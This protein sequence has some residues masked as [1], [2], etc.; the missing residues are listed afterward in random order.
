MTSN[1]F[2]HGV[3]IDNIS[4]I[5]NDDHLTAFGIA[6]MQ[7]GFPTTNALLNSHTF[8]Q[9]TKQNQAS[10]SSPA[11]NNLSASSANINTVQGH[12]ASESMQENT[13]NPKSE[14]YQHT[15]KY[16]KYCIFLTNFP[17]PS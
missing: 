1:D 16:Y 9:I 6:L 10:A 11:S 4:S 5:K 15:Q 13:W 14:S 12:S 3:G 8:Q 17:S 7:N 2:D